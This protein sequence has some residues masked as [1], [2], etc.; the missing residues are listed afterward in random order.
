MYYAEKIIDGVLHFQ[1]TPNGKW[2]EMS[3]EDLTSEIVAL[4][5]QLTE[6]Q[7]N[8]NQLSAHYIPYED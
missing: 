3:K 6:L 4:K 2:V 5:K 8:Y 1:I 7:E